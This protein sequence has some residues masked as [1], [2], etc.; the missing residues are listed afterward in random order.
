MIPAQAV[1]ILKDIIPMPLN[2]FFPSAK[3]EIY[4]CQKRLVTVS[5]LLKAKFQCP[6][7]NMDGLL[8]AE[9]NLRHARAHMVASRMAYQVRGDDPN[10]SC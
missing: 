6:G 3:V 8:A 10:P 7:A 5:T 1:G 4:K 2:M 9:E